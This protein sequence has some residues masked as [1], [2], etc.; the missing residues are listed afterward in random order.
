MPFVLVLVLAT[1]SV[2]PVQATV[3]GYL[4]RYFRM[5]PTKATEAGLHD[6]DRAIEDLSPAAREAWIAFDR[7]AR[8]RLAEELALPGLSLDDRIDAELLAAEIDRQVHDWTVLKRPERDPLFW[9]STLANATVFLLVRDD[10]PLADRL[11]RARARAAL[12]PRLAAQARET[13]SA[14]D[15][16]RIAP[17]LCR[18]AAN[19]AR[20]SAEFYRTGFPAAAGHEDAAMRDAGA[21]AA[22]SLTALASFLDRL[23]GRAS[24]DP[25]LGTDYADTFRL[26]TGITEPVAQVLAGAKRDLDAKRHEAAAYGRTVWAQLM[27]GEPAPA[28]DSVLL[29]HLFDRAAADRD[30]DLDGYVAGWNRNVTELER[31][32][33]DHH[34]MTLPDP[35]TLVVARSP[36]YFVGQSVG[37]VYAAGPYQPESKTILFLPVPADTASAAERD[38]F[39]RDFNRS[40]NR[41]IAAHELIPGHYVQLK[42]AAR[43]AH[44]VRAL[45]PDP[46]YVEGWGTFCEQAMLDA[47]WGGP[48]PRLAHLK[49]Q[50]ENIARTIVDIEVH[51]GGMSREE[52]TR[53]VKDDALQDDQFARNMWTRAIT[54]SPQLTFYYLGYREVMDVHDA[55]RR[56]R[57]EAFTLHDFLDGMMKMGPAPLKYYAEMFSR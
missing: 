54:S 50:L 36:S 13:L 10:L 44:K 26:G 46:V 45:F 7:Q 24:G 40:F 23:G 28:D 17:D 5:F 53:F 15:P 8:A 49:K 31:F 52:V 18:I 4:D 2:S 38:A 1:Q 25:R 43:Q 32:V 9:T 20:A 56:A 35:L 34:L 42:Y 14:G 33:R 48:L 21:K 11:E 51:T 27:P 12:V 30:H 3:N 41:M 22:G 47:G 16:T 37:G 39:Y 19:Q 29:R 6:Y 55:A 57:G